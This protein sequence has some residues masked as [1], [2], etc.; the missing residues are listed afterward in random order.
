MENLIKNISTVLLAI[1]TA[2]ILWIASSVQNLEVKAAIALEKISDLNTKVFSMQ[3]TN[4]LQW[5]RIN[6]LEKKI[7]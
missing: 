4:R 1:I 6:I 7:R 2:G 3:E 5:D